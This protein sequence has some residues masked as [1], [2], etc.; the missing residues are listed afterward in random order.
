MTRNT[1][2]IVTRE[3]GKGKRKDNARLMARDIA[4]HIIWVCRNLFVSAFIIHY[5][6]RLVLLRDILALHA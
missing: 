6:P 5:T 3:S 2:I 4:I 1:P